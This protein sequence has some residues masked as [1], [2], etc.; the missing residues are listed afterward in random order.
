MAPQISAN[1]PTS[2]LASGIPDKRP[3]SFVSQVDEAVF[4]RSS[5]FLLPPVAV[6]SLIG[7][8]V[9]GK[10]EVV[11][12]VDIWEE[13]S[14]TDG[15]IWDPGLRSAGREIG[16]IEVRAGVTDEPSDVFL[17]NQRIFRTPSDTNN[18]VP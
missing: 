11:G 17:L 12:E 1:G 14:V 10:K 7:G 18:A 13:P 16:E 8:R 4:L 6:S 15:V 3:A 9:A 5:E 2:S